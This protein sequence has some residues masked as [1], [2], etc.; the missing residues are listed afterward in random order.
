MPFPE[1][2]SDLTSR[3]FKMITTLYS[4]TPYSLISYLL[5][6][7][8]FP[9]NTSRFSRFL[10]L[11]VKNAFT[12]S[13]SLWSNLLLIFFF[14]P[15]NHLLWLYTFTPH[16]LFNFYTLHF[17]Q[18]DPAYHRFP[19]YTMYNR[20]FFFFL[21]SVLLSLSF[22]RFILFDVTIYTHLIPSTNFLHPVF[23][24]TPPYISSFFILHT[25]RQKFFLF[26]YFCSTFYII[27]HFFLCADICYD[28]H[29][30]LSATMFHYSALLCIC[31]NHYMGTSSTASWPH[32]LRVCIPCP[33]LFVNYFTFAAFSHTYHSLL[34][35]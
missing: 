5:D 28:Y 18:F 21:T 13:P 14:R 34:V 26:F 1:Y 17:S 16:L 11:S 23:F 20:S 31:T 10:R 7:H 6:I 2:L 35:L 3:L 22:N 8:N 24:T 33:L 9:S 32:G 30:S 27:A 29:N 19:H 15:F 25:V 4:N 12:P